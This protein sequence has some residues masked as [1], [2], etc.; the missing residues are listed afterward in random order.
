MNNPI[1]IGQAEEIDLVQ[2]K[3]RAM[4]ENEGVY[5]G[6]DS[7]QPN[8]LV[9]LVSQDGKIW[10]TRLDNELAP[11]RFLDTL[12]LHGPYVPQPPASAHGLSES[13]I[14]SIAGGCMET[15]RY[16]LFMTLIQDALRSKQ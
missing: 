9:V 12:T 7:R 13:E 16:D 10:D 8:L 4:L 6:G 15:G 1:L 2:P 11:E 5:I 3:V 14:A